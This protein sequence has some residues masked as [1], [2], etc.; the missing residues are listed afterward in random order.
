[1]YRDDHAAAVALLETTQRDL[2]AAQKDKAVDQQRIAYLTQ[3]L[4]YAQAQLTRL[5]QMPYHAPRF[6]PRGGTILTLGI[7]SV[8]VCSIMGPIAWSMGNEE[9]RRIDSGLTSPDGRSNVVAGK[10]LGIISTVLM[11]IAAFTVVF[12]FAVAAGH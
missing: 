12:V 1:M 6:A 10:I 4:Q 7:L 11:I 9:L 5:G 2:A 8:V 3:Q